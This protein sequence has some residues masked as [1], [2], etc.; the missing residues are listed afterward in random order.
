MSEFER[1]RDILRK[2]GLYRIEEGDVVYAELMAYCEG[3]DMCFDELDEITSECFIET[4]ESYGLEKREAMLRRMNFDESLAGR[5]SRLISALS[6]SRADVARRD[7]ARIC[8][9]FNAAGR[10]SFSD[11]TMTLT[12]TPETEMTEAEK[13]LFSEQLERFIP[14]WTKLIVA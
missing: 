2:T 11:D 7:F 4:A 14:C 12:F 13:L 8:D 5:R 3:L 10:F 9:S 6:V 1:M